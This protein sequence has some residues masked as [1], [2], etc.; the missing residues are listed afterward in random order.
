MA[1]RSL[2]C[3]HAPTTATTATPLPLLALEGCWRHCSSLGIRFILIGPAPSD[4]AADLVCACTASKPQTASPA[5]CSLK[6][7]GSVNALCGGHAAGGGSGDTAFFSVYDTDT[8]AS[9]SSPPPHPRDAHTNS[10]TAPEPSAKPG[11]SAAAAAAPVQTDIRTTLSVSIIIIILFFG[12]AFFAVACILLYVFGKGCCCSRRI[13]SVRRGHGQRREEEEFGEMRALTRLDLISESQFKSFSRSEAALSESQ[14]TVRKSG[15][16]RHDEHFLAELQQELFIAALPPHH[17][18]PRSNLP[19]PIYIPS[20]AL[21]AMPP[22]LQQSLDKDELDDELT[23]GRP[24]GLS[25]SAASSSSTTQTHSVNQ[26]NNNSS[27]RTDSLLFDKQFMLGRL[28]TSASAG[29][30]SAAESSVYMDVFA[31]NDALELE[32]K[33]EDS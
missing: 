33:R 28:Q 31:D 1:W 29:C 19:Q 6:C 21:G 12:V 13:D 15:L 2:A 32:M 14:S 25:P 8:Q 3:C 30:Q 4:A 5:L 7:P 10:T 22:Q 16:T 23:S 18:Y 17:P 24:W 11:T 27:D 26:T 20:T 9:V